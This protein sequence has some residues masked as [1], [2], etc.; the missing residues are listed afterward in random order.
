MTRLPLFR[1]TQKTS[2]DREFWRAY[3]PDTSHGPIVSAL[4]VST[5]Q[6]WNKALEWAKNVGYSK[7]SLKKLKVQKKRMIR[8]DS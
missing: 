4:K 7:T 6:D 1:W 3:R 2:R 8:R 5:P